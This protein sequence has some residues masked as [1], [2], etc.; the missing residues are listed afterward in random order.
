M[1]NF[2]IPIYTSAIWESIDIPLID[3]NWVLYLTK[4]NNLNRVS[5]LI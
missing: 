1:Y 5:H 2:M 3:F 4:L